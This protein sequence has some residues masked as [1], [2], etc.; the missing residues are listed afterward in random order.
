MLFVRQRYERERPGTSFVCRGFPRAKM[1][2]H[3]ELRL[4]ESRPVMEAAFLPELRLSAEG[5]SEEKFSR[6][7]IGGEV[8]Q[9]AAGYRISLI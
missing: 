6:Q 2:A 7:L 5:D 1:A 4:P 9:I 8:L 3:L